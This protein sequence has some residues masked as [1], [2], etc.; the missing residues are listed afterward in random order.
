MVRSAEALSPYRALGFVNANHLGFLLHTGA[1]EAAYRW[2]SRISFQC[3]LL[4]LLLLRGFSVSQAA[5]YLA[6]VYA[7]QCL[8]FAYLTEDI[9]GY[10]RQPDWIM[11]MLIIVWTLIGATLIR[12]EGYR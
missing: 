7:F 8:D 2:M 3:G 5:G 6:L 4:Y 12:L 11:N 9:D 1:T 10:P